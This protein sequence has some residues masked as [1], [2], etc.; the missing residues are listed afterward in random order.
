[1]NTDIGES[2]QD[3]Y[4]N[5]KVSKLEKER[6]KPYLRYAVRF[7]RLMKNKGGNYSFWRPILPDDCY[8]LG[9]IAMDGLTPPAK[10]LCLHKSAEDIIASPIKFCLVR[11]EGRISIWRPVAPD[12]YVSMGYLL[13]TSSDAPPIDAICCVKASHVAKPPTFD[14]V[15]IKTHKQILNV[16]TFDDILKTFIISEGKT[17]PEDGY[18]LNFEKE[19][20][21]E[22][23]K[24]KM[25]VTTKCGN[26]KLTVS[27]SVQTPKFEVQL[28]DILVSM[29]G[30]NEQSTLM[31]TFG[32]SLSSYN[33]K[34]F[35]WEP[36]VDKSELILKIRNHPSRFNSIALPKELGIDLSLTSP[37]HVTI[38]HACLESVLYLL[39]EWSD[40]ARSGS[41]FVNQDLDCLNTTV[42]N[43]TGSDFYLRLKY[44]NGTEKIEKIHMGGQE[45]LQ[46]FKTSLK[47][48]NAKMLDLGDNYVRV[49]VDSLSG[50]LAKEPN[51][52]YMISA[53]LQCKNQE[54]PTCIATRFFLWVW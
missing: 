39:S 7:Q 37:L 52:L 40:M 13:S 30:N 20:E 5:R 14:M 11:M 1:V 29:E 12:G 9:D 53:T 25:I 4:M 21:N 27:D 15:E 33:S 35:S 28:V 8:S 22:A 48:K 2:Q 10:I 51:M 19:N 43:E 16:F 17:L 34:L 46:P 23:D 45:V 50:S 49:T 32:L 3:I 36:I 47:L 26:I 42:T 41:L 44:N 54:V 31:C 6:S 24:K 38:A 18:V